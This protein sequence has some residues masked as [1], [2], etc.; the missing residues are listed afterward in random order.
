MKINKKI[1]SGVLALAMITSNFSGLMPIGG[2]LSASAAFHSSMNGM[3]DFQFTIGKNAN[4]GIVD[5]LTKVEK[6][7]NPGNPNSTDFYLKVTG[8]IDSTFLASGADLTMRAVDL[9]ISSTQNR[10][11]AVQLIVGD[12]ASVITGHIDSQ[13]GEFYAIFNAGPDTVFLP[14]YETTLEI[15]ASSLGEST[16]HTETSSKLRI[17]V[18]GR[19]VIYPVPKITT[20]VAAKTNLNADIIPNT[21]IVTANQLVSTNTAGALSLAGTTGLPAGITL[22]STTGLNIATT[23]QLPQTFTL[24]VSAPLTAT[25]SALTA[26]DVSVTIAKGN[27]VL[28]PS[29]LIHNEDAKTGTFTLPIY[30]SNKAGSFGTRGAV[31]YGQN[32]ETG[33]L[34]NVVVTAGNP[35]VVTWTSSSTESGKITIPLSMAGDNFYNAVASKDIVVNVT[36]LPAQN[37]AITAPTEVLYDGANVTTAVTAVATTDATVTTAPGAVTY[38][39]N[40]ASNIATIDATTGLVTW[41]GYG[42]ATVEATAA[43]TNES[44][45]AK[46]T[47]AIERK[48]AELTLTSKNARVAKTGPANID[49]I[50]SST[51]KL[52]DTLTALNAYDVTYK[53]STDTGAEIALDFTAAKD[54]PVGA[55]SFTVSPKTAETTN[56]KTAAGIAGTFTVS[57]PGS[58]SDDEEYLTVF[59]DVGSN[60]SITSGAA[61]EQT[62]KGGKPKH[63]PT[64]K[65]VTGFEHTGWSL[66]G[67]AVDPTSVTI[68]SNTT[69]KAMYNGEVVKP[70]KPEVPSDLKFDKEITESY[71][72]GDTEG[73]FRPDESI[74]RAE[75]ATIISRA[76]NKKMPQ[77]QTAITDFND[78]S[79]DSWYAKSVAFVQSM[80]L[81]NGYED[82]T[83]RPEDSITR[84]EAAVIIM[85]VERIQGETITGTLTD[86]SGNWAEKEILA[87]YANGLISGYPDGTFRPDNTITRAETVTLINNVLDIKP[88]ESEAVFGDINGH[89]AAS[90][91]T[92]AATIGKVK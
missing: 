51:V 82:G 46:A 48:K 1:T 91:I 55:Y 7:Q 20:T 43:G 41:T 32:S 62:V 12:P 90:Q 47:H 18:R 56:Y 22:N 29:N 44:G 25:H 8:R 81:I 88:M 72:K 79:S 36:G 54:L 35:S 59:Y 39:L 34:Q 28:T 65:G 71:I 16:M 49:A 92:A 6:I 19:N 24:K 50:V 64:V 86:I 45:E 76:L 66:D 80:G 77:D 60:G 17:N 68:N 58:S 70:E 85:R 42:S 26:T 5:Q 11:T 75:F 15:Q 40:P 27:Q 4:D 61:N 37:V 14:N 21:G 52:G 74:T 73:T 33:T 10:G 9:S 53:L 57:A 67:K 30:G 13:T 3:D 83:F 87:A 63:V 38:A 31:T 89:W 84:A 78:I 23:A 2:Q 69:F